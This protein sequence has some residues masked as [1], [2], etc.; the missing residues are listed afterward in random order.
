[1]HRKYGEGID[2]EFDEINKTLV[3][4]EKHDYLNLIEKYQKKIEEL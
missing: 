4:W 2:K 1:M 3:R